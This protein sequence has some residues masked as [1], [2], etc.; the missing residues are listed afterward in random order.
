MFCGNCGKE[1][2]DG[3]LFC[4]DCG[5]KVET[6]DGVNDAAN[7]SLNNSGTSYNYNDGN[8]G[9]GNYNGG[10]VHGPKWDDTRRTGKTGI[11]NFL[12]F[13]GLMW[14]NY[15]NAKGRATRTEFWSIFLINFIVSIILSNIWSPLSTIYGIA[16]LVPTIC[17]YV[18]RC[19]DFGK[20]GLFVV[21]VYVLEIVGMALISAGLAGYAYYL[22]WVPAWVIPVIVIGF[23]LLIAAIVVC[24][25]I[26]LK[27]SS[28]VDNEYGPYPFS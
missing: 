5:R 6:A 14:K 17:V 23:V 27:G 9:S 3:S 8:Y 20:S 15:A 1:L 25:V 24:F 18:R 4:P 28:P 21:L 10:A 12:G 26:G 11:M 22:Y 2:P 7:E 19:H 16:V 13:Y